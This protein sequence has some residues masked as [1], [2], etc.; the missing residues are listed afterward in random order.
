MRDP[1]S[2]EELLAHE[3][4]LRGLVRGIVRG[5]AEV[6]DVVQETWATALEKPPKSPGA[7]RAWLGRVARNVAF[8]RRRAEARRARRETVA[9]RPEG[10][11]SPLEILERESLRRKLVQT[12]L[13]L[14]AVYRDPIVLRWF[15]GLSVVE[16]AT[17]LGVPEGTAKTRLRRGLARLRERLDER[18]GGDRGAWMAAI[19]PLA[20]SD[21]RWLETTS[22]APPAPFASPVAKVACA[23]LA[24]V[25]VAGVA[26]WFALPG[27]DPASSDDH[28]AASPSASA[29]PGL[30]VAPAP[31]P[32]ATDAN[33]PSS[34]EDASPRAVAHAPGVRPLAVLHGF[35]VDAGGAAR[36]GVAIEASPAAGAAPGA[37]PPGIPPGATL[38]TAT[39]GRGRFEFAGVPGGAWHVR[40]AA[41]TDL[42]GEALAEAR[43]RAPWVRVVLAP[44]V[45]RATVRVHVAGVDGR[46]VEAARVEFVPDA[47]EPT[48]SGTTDATGFASLDVGR[49]GGVLR[50]S[51][52]TGANWMWFRETEPLCARAGKD[53]VSCVLSPTGSIAGRVRTRDGNPVA[54]A[55]VGSWRLPVM[56]AGPPSRGLCE[57]TT[58]DPRGEFSF[59]S[60]VPGIHVVLVTGAG[61]MV[62]EDPAGEEWDG[63]RWLRVEAGRASRLELTVVAGGVIEGTVTDEAGRALAGARVEVSLPLGAPFG[64]DQARVGDVPVWRLGS[65]WPEGAVHAY[66]R[67][68][69]RTD[70]GGRYRFDGLPTSAAWRVVASAPGRAF[71]SRPSVPVRVGETVTLSHRLG[72]AGALEALLPQGQTYSL[73][74]EGDDGPFVAFETPAGA[75]G[76]VTLAGL[77]PGRYALSGSSWRSED[78]LAPIAFEVRAGAATFVDAAE[79]VRGRTRLVLGRRGTPV[80]GAAVEDAHAMRLSGA[81]GVVEIAGALRPGVP[82]RIDLRGPEID[83]VRV[84]LAL[85]AS[86]WSAAV[87]ERRVEVPDDRLRIRVVGADRRPAAGATVRLRG[88]RLAVGADRTAGVDEARRTDPGG[89]ASFAALPAGDYD[90]SVGAVGART[91][92]VPD[93]GDVEMALP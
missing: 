52:A 81:D 28:P 7:L 88:T 56:R 27:T 83:A 43:D 50:A 93:D 51:H 16:V 59:D 79:S 82:L 61:G 21:A 62:A 78:A 12:V 14:D 53:P 41:G 49:G 68:I 84:S 5:E 22:R 13:A 67:R 29:E 23:A 42:A 80:A 77:A 74:R 9:A 1:A 75:S 4:F 76:A 91:V 11:P 69:A 30:A 86:D 35:V 39:D 70:E 8:G 63:Q 2:V 37:I 44:R 34:D 31:E 3:G 26:A 46:P 71:D 73:R 87:H 17:R 47:D 19:L 55:V 92:R 15:E 58:T 48:L 65:P 40:A 66:G 24:L 10:V 64:R 32:S 18:H 25:A 6:D 89:Y 36:A 90:L 85:P 72:P 45:E 38:R 57:V 54:D 60:V 33:A 20:G